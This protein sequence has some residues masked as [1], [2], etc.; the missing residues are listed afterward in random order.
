[1]DEFDGFEKSK[2]AFLNFL[3]SLIENQTRENSFYLTL[4]HAIRFLKNEK[5]D[6]CDEIEIEE[7]IGSDLYLKIAEKKDKCIL[8]LNRAHFDE[9]CYEINKIL[10]KEKFF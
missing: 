5:S 3:K 6:Q 1:M 10:I 8:D 2:T 7:E 4:L 9:M